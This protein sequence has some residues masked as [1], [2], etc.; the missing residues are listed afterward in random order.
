M[1]HEKAISLTIVDS[2]I[3]TLVQRMHE[4]YLENSHGYFGPMKE[5]A[6]T[7]QKFVHSSMY[8]DKTIKVGDFAI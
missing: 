4:V 3:V 8:S 5:V 1:Y 2:D 6:S 7:G